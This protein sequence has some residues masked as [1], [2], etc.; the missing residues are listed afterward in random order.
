MSRYEWQEASIKVGILARI[1]ENAGKSI[2]E[3]PTYWYDSRFCPR[4]K[5]KTSTMGSI[6]Y[7]L[8]EDRDR[9]EAVIHWICKKCTNSMIKEEQG[10]LIP[11][12]EESLE[13][14]FI[15]RKIFEAREGISK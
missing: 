14:W 10:M 13:N 11:Q 9:T 6:S 7:H 1:E 3:I 15:K 2:S 4:C 5:K 12:L 8:F